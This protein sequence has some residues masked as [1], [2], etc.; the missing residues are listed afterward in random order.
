[1]KVNVLSYSVLAVGFLLLATLVFSGSL[2]QESLFGSVGVSNEYQSTSTAP[3]TL[4]GAQ[5]AQSKIIKTGQG[6][7]GSVIITGANTGVIN[8]YNATTTDI[9]LR[10]GQVATSSILIASI[11]AST[12]AGTYTLDVQFTTG[13]IY[14]L[15]GGLMPTTTITYR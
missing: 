4:F 3:S 1:M 2:K 12:V 7:L 5:T 9:N 11:P 10:T 13:L 15:Y 14:D 6:A 8:F